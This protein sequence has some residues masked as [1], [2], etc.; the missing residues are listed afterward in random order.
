[1]VGEGMLRV[2]ATFTSVL[3]PALLVELAGKTCIVT[4]GMNAFVCHDGVLHVAA[5]AVARVLMLLQLLG[6]N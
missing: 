4:R 3:A 6:R 5:A 2:H 1:L